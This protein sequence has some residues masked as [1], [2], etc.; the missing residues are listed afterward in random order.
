MCGSVY[1]YDH[2]VYIAI[3]LSSLYFHTVAGIPDHSYVCLVFNFVHKACST[4][5]MT[6]LC[7]VNIWHGYLFY[8]FT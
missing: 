3:P 7:K 6:L 4:D 5:I 2:I 8:H 1:L